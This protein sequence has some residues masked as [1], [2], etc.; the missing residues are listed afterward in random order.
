[1]NQFSVDPQV[2]K[3]QNVDFSDAKEGLN[4]VIRITEEAAN[5]TMDLADE[6][7]PL[8]AELQIKLEK[9]IPIWR[10]LLSKEI[11][12][13]QFQTLCHNIDIYFDQVFDTVNQVNQLTNDI[14]VAQGFQDLSGQVLRRT[15]DVIQDW[16]SNLVD[17]LKLFSDSSPESPKVT[18]P[19]TQ[20][21]GPIVNAEKR[22]DVAK[23]QDEVDD[24]LSSLGF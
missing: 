21:E 18:K 22:S 12:V 10:K 16:Q 19:G 5:K 20:A 14:V 11:D 7:H 24:L 8:T 1:M 4:Y 23:S 3:L 6:L 15:I 17:I 9:F 13:N 2:K